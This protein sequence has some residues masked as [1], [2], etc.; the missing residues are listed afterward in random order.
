MKQHSDKYKHLMW[1]SA[2]ATIVSPMEGEPDNKAE[3][4]REFN[5]GAE[6]SVAAG[7][8]FD[9]TPVQDAYDK[10]KEVARDQGYLLETGAYGEDGVEDAIKE[11]QEALD[12]AGYQKVLKEFQKQYAEWLAAK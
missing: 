8:R 7:F 5:G 6:T 1:E 3:L 2:S 11:Y 10:C 9:R 4:Y 12:K